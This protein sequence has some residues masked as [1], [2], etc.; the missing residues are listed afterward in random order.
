MSVPSE[1][2]TAPIPGLDREWPNASSQ[3]RICSRCIYDETVSNISFDLQGVCNYCHQVDA[4]AKQYGT[5]TSEGR[6][7]LDAIIT[8]MKQAGRGRRYDCVV[9]VSGGTDS[10]Y[11]L[12]RC[13]EWGLR[14]L[15]VHYDNTWN[16]A[17]ATENIRKITSALG[18]DLSTYVMDN[19]EADDIFRAFFL[20][21]VPEFDA[22]TDIGF[23]QVLRSTASK[24]G[25]RY[26][27]EG[28]SFTAEGVSPLGSNYF[29]GKYIADIHRRF[30]RMRM[31]TFPNMP[32]G[33]FMKWTLLKRLKFIRPLWY[34]EYSKADAR[35]FLESQFGWQYYGGHHLENRSAAFAHNVYLPQKFGLDFRNWSIA[36]A[37]RSGITDRD[38]GIAEYFTHR[39]L[40]DPQLI[41]YFKKRTGFND[42]EFT[43]VMTGP[44]KSFRDYKTYK[45]R[46][47]R[48]RPLFKV[49]A[50]ANIVPRSFYLK[51]CFPLPSSPSVPA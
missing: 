51:Y 12:A 44:A 13:V 28:H 19:R 48:M 45:R 16:S 14:P 21:S 30:G 35:A 26:I 43:T 22:P 2:K 50:D 42:T 1:S 25:I 32:F 17:I 37:V 9:G 33:Q 36:A 27:L 46:F 29:D 41:A 31:R 40:P 39:P 38:E 4:L 5:G 49:L 34:L 3:L 7:K 11:L 20:A 18:V 24:H 23:A 47:E 8:Q 6:A 15:A 10:S